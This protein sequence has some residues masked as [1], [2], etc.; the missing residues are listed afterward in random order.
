MTAKRVIKMRNLK[1]K[2]VYVKKLNTMYNKLF[3][4]KEIFINMAL[5]GPNSQKLF[6]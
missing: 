2:S 3:I 1:K 4:F 6:D 5:C